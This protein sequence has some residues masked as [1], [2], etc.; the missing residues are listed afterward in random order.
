MWDSTTGTAT[1][2]TT[3]APATTPAIA[4]SEGVEFPKGLLPRK[5]DGSQSHFSSFRLSKI[6]SKGDTAV[7]CIYYT[8]PTGPPWGGTLCT[9]I[10]VT[11]AGKVSYSTPTEWWT[12]NTYEGLDSPYG[13]IIFVLVRTRMYFFDLGRIVTK[14]DQSLTKNIKHHDMHVQL[15]H[16]CICP[17]EKALA[18][19]CTTSPRSLVPLFPAICNYLPLFAAKLKRTTIC[20]YWPLTHPLF[21]AIC[22]TSSLFGAI[23]C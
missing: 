17:N 22:L 21:A 14:Y 9:A 11:Q 23:F 8:F 10:A 4:F 12:K 1:G 18:G 19:R 7:M 6:T 3:P 13:E 20:C 5:D 2:G 16:G 15:F